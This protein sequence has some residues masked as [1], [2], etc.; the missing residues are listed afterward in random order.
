MSKW[1][2]NTTLEQFEKRAQCVSQFYSKYEPLPG[3]HVN[4]NLTNGENIADMGRSSSLTRP[5][6][7]ILD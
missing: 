2:T 5:S 7:A 3:L 4:G 1:W 6:S